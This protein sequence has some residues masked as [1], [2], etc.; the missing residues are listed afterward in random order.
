MAARLGLYLARGTALTIHLGLR[1]SRDVDL[2]SLEPD[3]DI[4]PAGVF[5]LIP[6]LD[7]GWPSA[8]HDQAG[9]RGQ[10]GLEQAVGDVTGAAL[11]SD[12]PGAAQGTFAQAFAD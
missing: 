6:R 2:L 8:R 10:Q 11:I 12:A 5:T 3:L 9:Y 7:A 4:E 1:L